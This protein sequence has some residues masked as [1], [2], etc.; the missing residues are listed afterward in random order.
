F[1]SVLLWC[2]GTTLDNTHKSKSLHLAND[3]IPENTQ[4]TPAKK[5]RQPGTVTYAVK[6]TN[7]YPIMYVMNGFETTASIGFYDTITKREIKR[8]DLRRFNPYL[9]LPLPFEKDTFSNSMD[10]HVDVNIKNTEK[11]SI[12]RMLTQL[13]I[14]LQND[15]PDTEISGITIDALGGSISKNFTLQTFTFSVW[16]KTVTPLG[17]Q[18]SF[19]VFNNQGDII[20]NFKDSI[21]V[22]E[23][24]VTEDGRYVF[25]FFGGMY[26]CGSNDVIPSGFRIYESA[27]GKVLLEEK[28]PTS[29]NEYVT[30]RYNYFLIYEGLE[31]T[32]KSGMNERSIIYDIDN[33]KKYSK[34]FRSMKSGW[35][36]VVGTKITKDGAWVQDPQTK[37]DIR[38]YFDK[39]FTIIPLTLKR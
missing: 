1:Y 10:G 7:V 34:D 28:W 20:A 25:A 9:Q 32:P 3:S 27:N 24:A 19:Y 21:M 5:T 16:G 37:Q 12:K 35:E 13:G 31:Y 4:Q 30:S 33:K 14:S 17:G 39:D 6:D 38:L 18:T 2:G 23:A 15:K 11:S 22:G 36:K 29:A 26:G 8:I